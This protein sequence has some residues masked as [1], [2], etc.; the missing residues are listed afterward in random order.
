MQNSGFAVEPGTVR[1]CGLQ[2][3]SIDGKIQICGVRPK[4]RQV[5]CSLGSAVGSWQAACPF[6]LWAIAKQT[7]ARFP[8][9]ASISQAEKGK[10]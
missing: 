7:V 1:E 5:S 10:E 3:A 2:R 9:S 4:C 6:S 8:A